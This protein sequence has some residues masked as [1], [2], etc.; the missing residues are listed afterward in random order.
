M[1]VRHDELCCKLNPSIFSPIL[2]DSC[3]F[4]AVIDIPGNPPH[5]VSM[6]QLPDTS[7]PYPLYV[8]PMSTFV[9]IADCRPR[10]PPPWEHMIRRSKRHT[11][12]V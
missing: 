12:Y 11:S 2:A 1:E 5:S 9:Y 7:L 4:L 10:S 3:I 8:Q 6:H